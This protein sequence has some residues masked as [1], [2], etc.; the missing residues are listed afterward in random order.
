MNTDAQSTIDH[1]QPLPRL[2]SEYLMLRLRVAYRSAN[3]SNLPFLLSTSLSGWLKLL[4]CLVGDRQENSDF[5]K[6]QS[7]IF[8]TFF[9][10]IANEN[11][12]S[13]A[14]S[15]IKSLNYLQF[16]LGY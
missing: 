15:Q 4:P 11:P 7:N 2:E 9:N 3:P 12:K 14:L 10:N 13:T 1:Q 8:E 5:L 16:E 6:Q